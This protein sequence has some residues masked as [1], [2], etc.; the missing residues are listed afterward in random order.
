MRPG[1][2]LNVRR[3]PRALFLRQSIKQLR[4]QFIVSNRHRMHHGDT[5]DTEK[6][7]QRTNRVM[8][9]LMTRLLKFIN[10]P[11]RFLPSRRYVNTCASWIGS[12]V[13][14]D[15]ISRITSSL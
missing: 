1:D 5:E 4:E 11:T 14:T 8:P 10:R 6:Q 9:S 2:R 3:P 7:N 13:S 15:L 12:S